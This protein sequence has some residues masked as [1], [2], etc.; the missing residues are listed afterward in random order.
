VSCPGPC[1]ICG[2]VNY[3][4]SMGGSSIC[5]MC[6]TGFSSNPRNMRHLLDQNNKLRE[7]NEELRKALEEIKYGQ[8]YH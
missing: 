2:A 7:E 8:N 4:L 6:D 1:T 5:P 3:P